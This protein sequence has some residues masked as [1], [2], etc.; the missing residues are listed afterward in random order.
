M[1]SHVCPVTVY[2]M[3]PHSSFFSEMMKMKNRF[4]SSCSLAMH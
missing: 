1:T 4:N 2:R 3:I